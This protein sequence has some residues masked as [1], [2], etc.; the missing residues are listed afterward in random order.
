MNVLPESFV[1]FVDTDPVNR[2]ERSDHALKEKLF[3]P[4]KLAASLDQVGQKIF[5]PVIPFVYVPEARLVPDE[6]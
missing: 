3:P 6:I 5:E 4:E 2:H 1:L